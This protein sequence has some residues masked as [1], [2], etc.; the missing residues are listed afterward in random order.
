MSET[1]GTPCRNELTAK[2]HELQSNLNISSNKPKNT[3]RLLNFYMLFT[4]LVVFFF[5]IAVFAFRLMDDIRKF[6][7][8]FVAEEWP[9]REYWDE[10]DL[11]SSNYER[12]DSM[13]VELGLAPLSFPTTRISTLDERILEGGTIRCDFRWWPVYH[14][15][16][17][18]RPFF[19][20]PNIKC[21]NTVW[22]GSDI[23]IFNVSHPT[24]TT[25]F[26][27]CFML[28]D[29]RILPESCTIHIQSGQNRSIIS[30]RSIDGS[31]TRLDFFL[32]QLFQNP[33]QL[34]FTI[35]M[36]FLNNLDSFLLQ[37]LNLCFLRG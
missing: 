9:V 25:E 7:C 33:V 19:G 34:S 23:R 17:L 32:S 10:N 28:E 18:L 20:F 35:F 27:R 6:R 8:G 5:I 2:V 11:V 29:N 36:R 1:G 13:F 3:N 31:E 30:E 22:S 37:S 24:T 26:I 21:E 15:N 4:L 14:P 16:P 12:L